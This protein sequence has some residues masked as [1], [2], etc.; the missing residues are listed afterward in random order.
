[1][2]SAF[3]GFLAEPVDWHQD[4]ETNFAEPGWTLRG[5][6]QLSPWTVRQPT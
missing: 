3:V 1:V 5:S 6:V 4:A 2:P